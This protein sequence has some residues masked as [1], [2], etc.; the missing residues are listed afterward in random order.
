MIIEEEIIEKSKR[1]KTHLSNP[2]EEE[3]ASVVLTSVSP[4][5]VPLIHSLPTIKEFAPLHVTVPSWNMSNG[6]LL[7]GSRTKRSSIESIPINDTKPCDICQDIIPSLDQMAIQTSREFHKESFVCATCKL[8]LQ[9]P[10][11]K[12]GSLYCE[13]HAHGEVLHNNSI[14]IL[15][16]SNPETHQIANYNVYPAPAIALE[17]VMSSAQ[18]VTAHLVDNQSMVELQEGFQSGFRRLMKEGGNYLVFTGLKI[19]KMG[20]IKNELRQKQVMKFE[21]FQIR[22]RIGSEYWD[23]TPFKLVSSCTQL[24]KESQ[25]ETFKES[26]SGW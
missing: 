20:R 9:R 23:T 21:N 11:F 7:T 1:Q 5:L 17:K 26:T 3:K 6:T 15:I 2:W 22:F 13:R 14:Q 18:T 24:P 16:R 8:P 12:D 4:Y 25:S 19:N 10:H